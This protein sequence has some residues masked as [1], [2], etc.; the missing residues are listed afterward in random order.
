[1]T[2]ATTSS[3]L[4]HLQ[5][6]LELALRLSQSALG[7]I[8]GGLDLLRTTQENTTVTHTL[9]GHRK[10][11]NGSAGMPSPPTCRA[12]KNCWSFCPTGVRACMRCHRSS[13][14]TAWSLLSTTCSRKANGMVLTLANYR[15]RRQRPHRCLATGTLL[16]C[17]DCWVSSPSVCLP[18]S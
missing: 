5:Q 16:K 4:T 3:R 9:D 13:S 1:M 6:S 14:S 12:R 11:G 10:H 8:P 7:L 15:L 2:H 17:H 18:R